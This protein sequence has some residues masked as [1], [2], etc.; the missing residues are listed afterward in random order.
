[1]EVSKF[2]SCIFLFKRYLG[3]YYFLHGGGAVFVMAGRQF[4]LVSRFGYVKKFWYPLCLRKKNGS[5]PCLHKK[6]G[7][8]SSWK[9]NLPPPTL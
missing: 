8:P 4:F 7:T 6:T 3:S 9:H 1:M 2:I 5:P